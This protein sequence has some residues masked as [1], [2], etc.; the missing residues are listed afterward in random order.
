MPIFYRLILAALS[1]VLAGSMGRASETIKIGYITTLSTPASIIG[2]DQKDAVN[3]ALEHIGGEIAGKRVEVIFEDDGL[4]PD[5]GRQKAEKL[6]QQDNVDIV[7]GFIWT[8]VLL[9][10]QKPVLDAGKILISNNAGP[11][12]MA[13]QRCN[14]NFFSTRA[15]NDMLPHALGVSMNRNKVKRLYIIV[16]NYAGGKDMVNGVLATFKGEVAGT[17]Y[18]KWGAD[19]QLDFSAELAKAKASDADAL[20]AFFPGTAAGAFVKQFAQSG[21][22]GQVKLYSAFTIDQLSLPTFQQASVKAAIGTY[23]ADYWSPDLD[24]PVNR[25]FVEAFKVKYGRLPSNYAAAAYD[26][27]P[28][29]KAAVEQ[30]G[31][32]ISNLPAVRAAL[33]KANYQSVRGTYVVGKNGYPIDK[34]YALT[35]VDGDVWTTKTEA[36]VLEDQQDP[37]SKDCPLP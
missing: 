10:A 18:T 14:V 17:D 27:L 28:Y 8:N 33:R 1:L 16:P 7:A 30:S 3:L 31:G 12:E 29:V 13:G 25:R 26:L 21:L 4:K 15:Q 11:S 6:I 2:R 24:N 5:L 23:L 32:D 35:T 34:F 9:A 37:Y 36:L 19:P 20:Y 22:A